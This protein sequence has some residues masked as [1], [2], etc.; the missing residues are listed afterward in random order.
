MGACFLAS[1][2][3]RLGFFVA[4]RPK[5]TLLLN[6]GTIA[7][8]PRTRRD[9][10]LPRR[11]AQR[12]WIL[13]EKQSPSVPLY[14]AYPAVG[15]PGMEAVAETPLY[16]R[17]GAKPESPVPKGRRPVCKAQRLL[18]IPHILDSRDNLGYL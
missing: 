5:A 17:L 12:R 11:V 8:G 16:G 13:G 14:T 4:N 6:G 1:Q 9:R 10:S 7:H 18:Y 2:H 15:A 3:C